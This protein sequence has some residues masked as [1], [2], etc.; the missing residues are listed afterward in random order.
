MT[1]CDLCILALAQK[2]GWRRAYE[3]EKYVVNGEMCGSEVDTR[4]YEVFDKNVAD[5]PS[6]EV[7]RIISGD[8]YT[9]ETKKDGAERWWR[10]YLS[11][12]KPIRKLIDIVLPDG[13]RAKREVWENVPVEPPTEEKKKVPL[14]GRQRRA[15]ELWCRQVAQALNDAGLSM[16]L[17]LS[18]TVELNWNHDSVKDEMWKRVQLA[19]KKKESTTQLKKTGE[20]DEI[21]EHLNRFLGNLKNKKGESVGIHVPWPHFETQ[22]EYVLDTLK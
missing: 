17:V 22:E 9:I 2:G 11:A 20:I 8:T 1:Q 10:A 16:Q 4:L 3:L 14:T 18:Q 5:A 21:Y 19:L 13:T 7:Q 12:K 15:L 6:K